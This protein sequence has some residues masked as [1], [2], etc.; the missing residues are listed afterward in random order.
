MSW[1]S[2]QPLDRASSAGIS[3]GRRR[4]A[5]AVCEA[6]GRQIL[7]SSIGSLSRPRSLRRVLERAVCWARPDTARRLD[8]AVSQ[9]G[10]DGGH[11]ATRAGAA[12]SVY[13]SVCSALCCGGAVFLHWT[14][15]QPA[16][17]DLMLIRVVG[18]AA[19]QLPVGSSPMAS[20]RSGET[21]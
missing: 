14:C 10:T 13:F 11:R 7:H 12:V 20:G 19:A 6:P 5:A 8:G 4:A 9:T 16:D 18:G 15:R 1:P 17:G 3:G 21:I 2:P